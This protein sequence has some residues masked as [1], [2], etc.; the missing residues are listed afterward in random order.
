M[1]QSTGGSLYFCGMLGIFGDIETP[2]LDTFLFSS[3]ISAVDP[4]AVLAVFEEIHVN[5]ILYIVVFGESLLNDAVTVVLYHMFETYN[6]MGIDMI[7][8]TD[9]VNGFLNFLCVALGGVFVGMFTFFAAMK[10]IEIHETFSSG[11]VWGF[12]TGL[13][14]RFTDHVRVIEP[15]FVFV[16]AYLAYLNAEIFHWSGILA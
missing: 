13:V 5:E 2:I 12:L 8:V 9:L 15:I 14:T 4:V 1:R 10:A 6:E 7:Q 11:V 16:M 3:L